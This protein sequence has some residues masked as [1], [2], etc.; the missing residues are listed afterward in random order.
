MIDSP[1]RGLR[2]H[3]LQWSVGIFCA[4]LG[5]LMLVTPHQFASAAYAAFA[6]QLPW[7]GGMFVAAG[8]A[9][10]AVT[11][12]AP[13]RAVVV[14][15]HCGAGIVLLLLALGFTVTGGWTGLVVY[16]LLAVGVA[17]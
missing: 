8:A 16:G 14:A 10:I 9:L 6:L 1:A 5:A 7:W 2:I 3:T 4:L 11:A 13:Q 15:V 17:A 12:L